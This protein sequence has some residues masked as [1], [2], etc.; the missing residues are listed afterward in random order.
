[1]AQGASQQSG[2]V[3][4]HTRVYAQDHNTVVADISNMLDGDAWV[5]VYRCDSIDPPTDC[6]SGV[7]RVCYEPNVGLRLCTDGQETVI[8]EGLHYPITTSAQANTLAMRDSQAAS[9]FALVRVVN[10][11]TVS[12]LRVDVYD[13][14]AYWLHANT[15]NMNGLAISHGTF[16]LDSVGDALIS[17]DRCRAEIVR[18][19]MG[20]STLDQGGAY[21]WDLTWPKAFS[22]V[23]LVVCQVS[24][25]G[26]SV[27]NTDHINQFRIK[28]LSATGATIEG[29][30]DP[31]K[32]YYVTCVAIGC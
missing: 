28:S 27:V 3:V 6:P 13:D 19:D 25:D 12:T 1:M 24:A 20:G 18:K 9:S 17:S 10:G 23:P 14:S 22:T 30:L 32:T 7:T 15:D 16:H 2:N 11:G 26:D 8:P 4:P 21:E 29:F 31:H 5:K